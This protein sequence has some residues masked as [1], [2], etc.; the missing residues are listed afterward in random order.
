MI[1]GTFFYKQT[2]LKLCKDIFSQVSSRGEVHIQ[3][4]ASVLAHVKVG[5]ESSSH[6]DR[7]RVAKSK[8]VEP[9]HQTLPGDAERFPNILEEWQAL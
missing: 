3:P 1:S 5:G 4:S 2:W 7:C 8:V 6:G 9:E